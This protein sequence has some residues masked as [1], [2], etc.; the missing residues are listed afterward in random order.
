MG[1]S[2]FLQYNEQKWLHRSYEVHQ[3]S[4][5]DKF[6]LI[7]EVWRKFIENSQNCYKPGPYI[8]IDEQLFPT[9]ARYRSTQYMP[10]KPNKFGIKFFWFWLASDIKTKYIINGFPYLGKGE[11]RE[12]SVIPLGEFVTLKFVELYGLWKKY[13]HG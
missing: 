6:F 12:T 2:I 13:N 1:S 10:N 7:S 9:K 3:R 4:Q 11:T 8:S 5:T